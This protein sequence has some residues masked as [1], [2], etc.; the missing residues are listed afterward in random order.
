MERVEGRRVKEQVKDAREDREM[1][2]E[3]KAV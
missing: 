2:S 3:R 1:G